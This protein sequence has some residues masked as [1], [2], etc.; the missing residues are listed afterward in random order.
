MATRSFPVSIGAFGFFSD[1]E[2]EI[3]LA[4]PQD[5]TLMQFTG[6]IDKNGREIYE[7]DIVKLDSWEGVQQIAF[8]EGAFCLTDAK[9][10]FVGDIHYVH[11]AD[12]NQAS[13]IGNI[14]EN[15]EL[16]T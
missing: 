7:G 15:P 4:T 8:V 6:L 12:H 11:H 13:I 14:Y 1:D 10:N 16:L 5:V 2:R 9:G 3:V